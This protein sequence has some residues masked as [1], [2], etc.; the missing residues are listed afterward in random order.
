MIAFGFALA[1][2]LPSRTIC[3]FSDTEHRYRLSDYEY[4]NQGD[5]Y[6]NDLA[7]P[8]KLDDKSF[9]FVVGETNLPGFG[10]EDEIPQVLTTTTT[11]TTTTTTQGSAF[12]TKQLFML[13]SNS[14]LTQYL[15]LSQL[16]YL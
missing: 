5:L 3:K 4:N 2:P 10:R 12:I 6:N 13:I 11:S 7:K 8:T 1:K 14:K 16:D 9:T 15:S